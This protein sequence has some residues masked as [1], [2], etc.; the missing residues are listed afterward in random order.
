MQS[1]GSLIEDREEGEFLSDEEVEEIKMPEQSSHFFKAED[2]HY[3]LTKTIKVLK[4]QETPSE[5]QTPS[6][7]KLKSR[8][9]G[10]HEF[11]PP[12]ELVESDFP[13]PDYFEQQLRVAWDRPTAN[14]QFPGFVR[15]M[16]AL[17]SYA[18]ELLQ[19]PPVDGPVVAI[20]S[21]DLVSED[22][23]GTIQDPIDKK[24]DATQKRL[25]ESVAMIVKAAATASITFR[26]SI[27]WIRKLIQMLPENN[28]GLLEG[29]MRILKGAS[30]STDTTLDILSFASRPW[31]LQQ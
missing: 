29:V 18:N 22:G 9:R 21:T 25:H 8:S 11:F 30:F 15:K 24:A 17:P 13:F 14:K 5:D 6:R 3:F 2:C 20:Q 31:R 26:A 16:Y 12:E 19:I 23:H 1:M 28:R 7:P 10:D 4:I 27:V